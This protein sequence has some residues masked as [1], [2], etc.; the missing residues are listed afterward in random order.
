MKSSIAGNIAGLLSFFV[1]IKVSPDS[2]K[3]IVWVEIIWTILEVVILAIDLLVTKQ[4]RWFDDF[5]KGI[6]RSVAMKN[7]EA[8]WLVL[9]T[10]APMSIGN[11][12]MTVEWE[13]LAIF[14]AHLGGNQVA[15]WGI[16]GT[17]WGVLEYA[18][19]CVAAAGEIRVAKLLGNGNPRLA[20]LSAYKCLFLGNMFATLMSIGFLLGMPFIPDW[21]TDDDEL[22]ALVTNVLP[23]CAIGNLTLTI[24][25]L[26]WT[27]V[28][29]QGRYN[30]ATF[31]GCIGS[32]GITIPFAVVSIFYLNWGL[33]ALAASVVIGYMVSGAF[34]SITL[35]LSDWEY[36]SYRVM[37]RNGAT[38]P[39]EEDDEDAP[40]RWNVFNFMSKKYET[41]SLEEDDDG[42]RGKKG[43]VLVDTLESKHSSLSVQT[44][45]SK[46]KD[47][48]GSVDSTVENTPVTNTASWWSGFG[49]EHKEGEIRTVIIGPGKLGYTI[50]ST[51]RGPMIVGCPQDLRA[52]STAG[53]NFL[54]AITKQM[55]SHNNN[56]APY[57]GYQA[58]IIEGELYLG[59]IIVQVDKTP[60]DKMS[61]KDIAKILHRK[62]KR[63]LR[64]L[65]VSHR[66]GTGLSTVYQPGP[67]GSAAIAGV[68]K[69]TKEMDDEEFGD[70]GVFGA[71][72][73]NMGWFS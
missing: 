48:K 15:A 12:I 71:G 28:G 4:M 27:L 60:T 7:W 67:Y 16:V 42:H 25:S 65:L 38:E 53:G 22:R 73:L 63:T 36:I 24:G 49:F 50:Q 29:A 52:H 31:H 39:I 62:Q 23:Y 59:D 19:D 54:D 21:F 58:K 18:T 69:N 3:S 70:D 35:L 66:E 47:S 2:P 10:A 57:S 64:T 17:I 68:L 45:D 32:L 41:D 44:D 56:P 1:Y 43:L 37:I 46:S 26:A 34:N 33:P 51:H 13:L 20:K 5:W 9:R 72:Y 40:S 11:I 6:L 61:G 55:G 14:A 8:V 30:V